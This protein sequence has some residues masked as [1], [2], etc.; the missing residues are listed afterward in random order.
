MDQN[1][2]VLQRVMVEVEKA[3]DATRSNIPGLRDYMKS[4]QYGTA[5]QNAIAGLQ[6]MLIVLRVTGMTQDEA[7]KTFALCCARAFEVDDPDTK[8]TKSVGPN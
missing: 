5:R 4:M 3:I 8:Q 6:Y 1:K 2:E 7:C